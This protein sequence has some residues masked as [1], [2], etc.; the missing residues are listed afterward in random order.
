MVDDRLRFGLSQMTIFDGR[1]S[2]EDLMRAIEL[3]Q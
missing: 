1:Q 3:H 2:K